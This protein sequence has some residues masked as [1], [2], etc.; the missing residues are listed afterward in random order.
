MKIN[1][2]RFGAIAGFSF[3]SLIYFILRFT[4]LTIIPVF[5]DEAIYTHWSQIIRADGAQSFIPLSDGKQP[6][7]MWVGAFFMRFI[8]NPLVAERSVSVIAGFFTMFGLFLLMKKLFGQRAALISSI[9]YV[10]CPF[11]FFYDRLAVADG[12]LTAFFV[13][14]ALLSVYLA[15]TLSLDKSLMLGWILGGGLLTKSTAGLSLISAPFSL[16]LVNWKGEGKLLKIVKFGALMALSVA[17]GLLLYTILRLSPLYYLINQRTPD[18]IFTPKEV[19]KHPIDPFI[20]RF[21]GVGEWL[22]GYMTFPVI[23]LVVAGIGL[24]LKKNLR[25]AL[26]LLAWFLIPLLIEMEIAK[27]FTPR[28]F[29][30]VA[31]IA[32]TFPAFFID[33]MLKVKKNIFPI[34]FAVLLVPAAI[35]EFQLLT[36]PQAAPIPDK[37]K[38][39]YLEQWSAGYGIL[40]IS[41]FLRAQAQDG[42][43]I[44]VF[45]EGTQG[46]G[47]LPDGLQIYLRDVT[48]VTVS[49]VNWAI[50]KEVPKDLIEDAKTQRAYL[51][52]NEDRLLDKG[53]PHL[54]LIMSYPKANGKDLLLFYQVTN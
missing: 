43:P 36:N 35:F 32:L 6:L 29:V 53:N 42:Q 18:F 40:E 52:V 10:L 5:V 34:V 46:Y 54:K 8:K 13:Y 33:Q 9:L 26:F 51:V 24:M 50:V 4:H 27:G 28:Y 39:G 11:M 1:L 31:P 2:K 20:F 12:L 23:V 3:V 49:G 37:E 45:T 38:D 19:L 44:T 15:E 21:K 14:T 30:F 7:F 41:Q 22:A 25:T 48:N 47:T 17:G 16:L